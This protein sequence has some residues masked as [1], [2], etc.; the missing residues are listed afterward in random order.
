[1][2]QK[3]Y[4][5]LASRVLKARFQS[6]YRVSN[7]QVPLA[8]LGFFY[9]IDLESYRFEF[10]KS[11]SKFT[12]LNFYSEIDQNKSDWAGVEKQRNRRIENGGKDPE[13]RR[14]RRRRR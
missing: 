6:K 1:M 5:K 10:V 7:T 4:W 9:H 13:G 12:G 2:R 8:D 14:R 3:Q 11:K